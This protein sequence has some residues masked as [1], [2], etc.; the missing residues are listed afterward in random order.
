MA[1]RNR[2]AVDVDSRRID[3]QL[4][5]NPEFHELLVR[6]FEFGVMSPI[7]RLHGVRVPNGV[8][9]AAPDGEYDPR[10]VG[11][12]SEAEVPD[13]PFMV[14]TSVTGNGNGGHEYGV[15]LSD[16]DRWALVEYLKTL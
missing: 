1:E 12:V 9:F 8:P 3:L 15:T 7:C 14:D 10:K 11:Y 2:S 6:W 5:E 13:A 4:R 16:A